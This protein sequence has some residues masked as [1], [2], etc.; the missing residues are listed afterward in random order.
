M[1]GYNCTSVPS[2]TEEEEVKADSDDAKKRRRSNA[3]FK[4]WL[5][6]VIFLDNFSTSQIY[7]LRFD[8][9][10]YQCCRLVVWIVTWWYQFYLKGDILARTFDVN[11]KLALG[12]YCMEIMYDI[13]CQSNEVHSILDTLLYYA[14]AI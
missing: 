2:I 9:N 4:S 8:L 5:K 6:T 14:G 3:S 13:L 7:V 11:T 12:S 10:F 1:H